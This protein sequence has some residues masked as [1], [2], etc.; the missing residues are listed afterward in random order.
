M[1]HFNHMNKQIISDMTQQLMVTIRTVS[2]NELIVIKDMRS[3]KHDFKCEEIRSVYTGI[4][5][6]PK[7]HRTEP[8]NFRALVWSIFVHNDD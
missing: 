6:A 7:H 5:V 3:I 2:V 4:R 1:V 8:F